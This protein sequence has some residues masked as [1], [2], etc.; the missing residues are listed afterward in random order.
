MKEE[1]VAAAKNWAKNLRFYLSIQKS[2]T[3]Y[4]V[5]VCVRGDKKELQLKQLEQS[6]ASV[7]SK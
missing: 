4:V 3:H 6:N 1:F 7:L 5:M 2:C